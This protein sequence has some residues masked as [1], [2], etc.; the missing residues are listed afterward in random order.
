MKFYAVDLMSVHAA[1]NLCKQRRKFWH[2]STVEAKIVCITFAFM[3]IANI[4]IS[5][6]SLLQKPM[7]K[8]LFEM[9]EFSDYEH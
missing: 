5:K 1:A 2:I 3:R 4:I 8:I 9:P 6:F 7:F